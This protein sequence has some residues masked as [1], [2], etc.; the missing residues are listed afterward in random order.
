MRDGAAK[1]HKVV[2]RVIR[3]RPADDEPLKTFGADLA[4]LRVTADLTCRALAKTVGIGRS[5]LDDYL[6]GRRLPSRATTLA[7]V[8]TCHGDEAEWSERWKCLQ[9]TV[10]IAPVPAPTE[11]ESAANGPLTGASAHG[12]RPT[13]GSEM[14]VGADSVESAV[15]PAP[16][17]G[18]DVKEP[19]AEAPVTVGANEHFPAALS[20][21]S[22]LPRPKLRRERP[23]VRMRAGR[24][25]VRPVAL[26]GALVFLIPLGWGAA[27]FLMG[28]GGKE[29]KPSDLAEAAPVTAVPVVAGSTSTRV[30]GASTISRPTL[31]KSVPG[32]TVVRTYKAKD[33]V[34][35]ILSAEKVSRG[36]LS[37]GGLVY[38]VTPTDN[39][40]YRTRYWSYVAP[41]GIWGYVDPARLIFIRQECVPLPD[42]SR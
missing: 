11:R 14:P 22:K 5:T 30:D 15:K 41:P 42:S 20:A 23:T 24:G 3:Q 17:V 29:G 26:L 34:G 12:R 38:V 8:R 18:V 36:T 32:C 7:I 2:A 4:E 19:E 37:T 6:A 40:P 39:G 9:A 21:D 33:S 1:G 35:A 28:L 27:G 13:S 31:G 25:R 10:S 16:V